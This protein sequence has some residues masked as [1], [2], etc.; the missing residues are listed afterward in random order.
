M[1]RIIYLYQVLSDN[2]FS[3]KLTSRN[4]LS[5]T[6]SNWIA[7]IDKSSCLHAHRDPKRFENP[8]LFNKK[9]FFI[10]SPVGKFFNSQKYPIIKSSIKIV[11]NFFV[12]FLDAS[13][14]YF[15]VSIWEY[16]LFLPANCTVLSTFQWNSW[17]TL[18]L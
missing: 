13:W 18:V 16:K 2:W 10:G 4:N 1:S 6:K 15:F 5:S 14:P 8:N 17:I 7:R 11:Q 9:W 3:S 12:L